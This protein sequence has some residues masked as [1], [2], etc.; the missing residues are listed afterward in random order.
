MAHDDFWRSDLAGLY[1]AV[2]PE[3]R[4]GAWYVAVRDV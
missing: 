2:R 1:I 4:F 3:D